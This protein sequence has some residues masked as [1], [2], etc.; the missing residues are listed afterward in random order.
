MSQPPFARRERQMEVV[1][2]YLSE[3]YGGPPSKQQMGD[4]FKEMQLSSLAILALVLMTRLASRRAGFYS[5]TRETQTRM[6]RW[7]SAVVEEWKS[8]ELDLEAF[9]GDFEAFRNANNA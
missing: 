5:E 6:L 9:E 4:F 8:Y 7:T 1:F 2:R 3:F